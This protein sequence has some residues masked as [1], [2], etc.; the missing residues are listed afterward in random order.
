MGLE[1]EVVDMRIPVLKLNVLTDK[2]LEEKIS[3]AK[4]ETQELGNKRILKITGE[5]TR[6]ELIIKSLVGGEKRE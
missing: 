2:S 4:M 1:G 3:A 6:M 5:L